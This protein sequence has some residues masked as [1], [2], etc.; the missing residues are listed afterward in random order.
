MAS[1]FGLALAAGLA[2]GYMTQQGRNADRALQEKRF[3]IEQ[4]RADREQ[5]RADREQQQYDE[6]QALKQGLKDAA[7]PRSAVQGQVVGETGARSLYSK[8]ALT[9]AL[10]ESLQ[11][12][13]DMRAE[14]TGKPAG[15]MTPRDGY[16][17]VGMSKGNEITDKA[18]DLAAL[19]S[20]AAIGKRQVLSLKQ[21]GKPLESMQLN[22]AFQKEADDATRRQ[23][24]AL[25][26]HDDIADW[27]TK[28]KGDGKG[29]AIKMKPMAS[30]DGKAVVYHTINDDGTTTPTQKAFQNNEAGLQEART[31]LAGYL[32]P[33]MRQA[34]FKDLRES[35]RK[36]KADE[37]KFTYQQA[38]LDAK[39][40]TAKALLQ[41]AKDR[42]ESR[43]EKFQATAVL[44]PLLAASSKSVHDAEKRIDDFTKDP[45]A[46]LRLAKTDSAEAKQLQELKDDLDYK[47]REKALY[48]SSLGGMAGLEQIEPTKPQPTGGLIPPMGAPAKIPSATP[49]K[50]GQ[51]GILN[52]EYAK[53]QELLAKAQAAGDR[54]QA[55]RLNVDLVSLQSEAKRLGGNLSASQ[56]AQPTIAQAAAAMPAQTG[57]AQVTNPKPRGYYDASR[58]NMPWQK[59][60]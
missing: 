47:K 6:Q 23:I 44:A 36:T 54:Q 19:N 13:A 20:D 2:N 33:E 17:I 35:E 22:T 51:L 11:A 21:A 10:Q 34:H 9:P 30:A 57:L 15:L 56:P 49:D 46:K 5:S 48:Q 16:G 26:S 31:T 4:S 43:G 38:V 60:Q 25:Q 3:A 18:P 28:T 58:N 7:A 27:I 8:D 32:S 50:K 41:S 45:L 52:Q 59:S 40:E 42:A 53:T 29:G 12:E 14:P 39:T 24:S 1:N 37:A 55:D